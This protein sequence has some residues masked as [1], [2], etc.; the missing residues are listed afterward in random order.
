LF[1]ALQKKGEKVEGCGARQIGH[2]VGKEQCEKEL[3]PQQHTKVLK[4]N[5]SA[6]ADT[7]LRS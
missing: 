3:H 2:Y 5:P 4:K 6:V 1:L 7:N